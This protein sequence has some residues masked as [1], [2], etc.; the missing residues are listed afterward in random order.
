MQVKCVQWNGARELGGG[1]VRESHMVMGAKDSEFLLKSSLLDIMM[2]F[3]MHR[4]RLLVKF[5]DRH[6]PWKTVNAWRTGK[7]PPCKIIYKTLFTNNIVPASRPAARGGGRKRPSVID[8]QGLPL[9]PSLLVP[10]HSRLTF[11]SF[12]HFPKHWDNKPI[13]HSGLSFA[14]LLHA[15]TNDR[16][17]EFFG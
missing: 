5:C 10:G 3:I 4:V 2:L 14:G 11:S 7:E 16:A 17:G 1:G 15:H 8:F 12:P 6:L 13:R 9:C